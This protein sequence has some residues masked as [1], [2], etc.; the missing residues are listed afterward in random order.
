V[1]WGGPRHHTEE[2][3]GRVVGSKVGI[4]GDL[5]ESVPPEEGSG[6]ASGGQTSF[7]ETTQ[8]GQEVLFECLETRSLISVFR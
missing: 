7:I 1:S 3:E 5:I 4:G 6:L 2:S 8:V